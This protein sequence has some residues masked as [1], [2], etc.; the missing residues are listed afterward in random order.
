MD[1]YN[2]PRGV[3][4]FQAGGQGFAAGSNFEATSLSGGGWA[5]SNGDI[6][7]IAWDAT[8]GFH[9][10]ALNNS[11]LNGGDPTTG[12]TGTGHVGAYS[13]SPTLYPQIVHHTMGATKI[14]TANF[15]FTPPSGYSAWA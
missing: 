12:A 6:M 7:A 5:L 10:L 14:K 1:Y 15:N 3:L 11:W 2:P 4:S 13:G 9:Y 8:N